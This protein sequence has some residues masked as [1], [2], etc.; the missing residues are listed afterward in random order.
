MGSGMVGGRGLALACRRGRLLGWA[1]VMAAD[2]LAGCFGTL[3]GVGFATA[4]VTAQVLE[5]ALR[6]V[7]ELSV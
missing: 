1:L 2:G 4:L 3:I 6:C 7:L 5:L